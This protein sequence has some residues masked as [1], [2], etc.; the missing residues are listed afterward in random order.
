MRLKRITYFL[1]IAFFAMLIRLWF[2]GTQP[3]QLKDVSYGET[4][5]GKQSIEYFSPDYFT[6]RTRFRKVVEKAGGRLYAIPLAAKGP[7]NEDLTI[8]VGWIGSDHP[9]RVLLHSS[10]LHGVEGFAGSAIQLELLDSLPT[11]PDDTALVFVHALNPYGMAW[12]RRF[13]EKQRGSEPK[14][15]RGWEILWRTGEVPRLRLLPQPAQSP[16]FGF[17]SPPGRM[18]GSSIWLLLGKA[19][20]C[21]R[22]V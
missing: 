6:A 13:N 18:A 1:A 16:R 2:M 14:F 5:M 17:L 4:G 12:L 11:L 21:R 10:G 9:K 19:G 8:D 3:T 22:T 15:P 7:G 20:H